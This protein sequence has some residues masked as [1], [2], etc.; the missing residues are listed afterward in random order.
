MLNNE[1]IRV[2]YRKLKNA[3]VTEHTIMAASKEF[4]YDRAARC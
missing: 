1:Q 3:Y 4:A 2:I